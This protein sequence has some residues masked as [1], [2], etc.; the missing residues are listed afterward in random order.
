MGNNNLIE[1]TI[2]FTLN[3]EKVTTDVKS[4]E[5]LSDTLRSRLSSRDVKIGCNAGDCLSLIH[6]SEPTRPY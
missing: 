6:I 4:G 1:H 5:R 2:E 3:G